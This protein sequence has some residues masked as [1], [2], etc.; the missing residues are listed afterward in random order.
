MKKAYRNEQN[1]NKAERLRNTIRDIENQLRSADETNAEIEAKAEL[2]EQNI[3]R[4]NEGMK[5]IYL[6]RKKLQTKVM[7]KRFEKIK[8]KGS[9]KTYLKKRKVKAFKKGLNVD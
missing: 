9:I 4:M 3:R 2:R 1:P 8:S 7:E 5:P 6:N